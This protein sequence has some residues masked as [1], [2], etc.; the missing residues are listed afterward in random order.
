MQPITIVVLTTALII[1]GMSLL[2]AAEHQDVESASHSEVVRTTPIPRQLPVEPL[3][4][5]KP[6]Q[7]K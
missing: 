5:P 1:A 3:K 4:K 7:P 6:V 2:V